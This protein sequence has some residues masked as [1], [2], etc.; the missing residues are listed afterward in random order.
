MTADCTG[1]KITARVPSWLP[2]GREDG[3]G[4]GGEGRRERRAPPSLLTAGR[5]RYGG[6]GGSG[7]PSGERGGGG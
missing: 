2:E 3:N 7:E 6:R 1:E 5:G 4:G